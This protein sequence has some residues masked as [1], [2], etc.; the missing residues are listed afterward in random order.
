MTDYR[1]RQ[2]RSGVK[3]ARFWR[4]ELAEAELIRNAWMG[5]GPFRRRLVRRELTG[6]ELTGCELTG[7]ERSDRHSPARAAGD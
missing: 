6:W 2:R 7:C 4:A 5:G 3:G 1:S